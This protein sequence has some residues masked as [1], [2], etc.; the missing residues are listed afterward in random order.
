MSNST[1]KNSETKSVSRA[2]TTRR[3][4][5]AKCEPLEDDIKPLNEINN[6]LKLVQKRL[7]AIYNVCGEHCDPSSYS[8]WIPTL[9]RLDAA[10]DQAWVD[11]AKWEYS[12]KLKKLRS[13]QA[14]VKTQINHFYELY[15]GDDIF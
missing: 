2:R 6:H 7:T 10:L 9:V 4:I 3:D 1:S 12:A 5:W 13:E 11:L 8:N 14:D 15:E